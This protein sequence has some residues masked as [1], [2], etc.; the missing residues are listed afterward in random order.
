[1]NVEIVTKADLQE[2]KVELLESIRTLLSTKETPT[3]RP[4]LKS[5]EVR[6]LLSCS[7]GTLQNLRI[8]QALT[9]TK[10]G[11]TWYYE[12]QQVYDLLKSNSKSNPVNKV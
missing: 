2:L 12:S 9:P 10:I 4:W 3:A 1:M 7:P 6:T 8:T 11:G 5:A